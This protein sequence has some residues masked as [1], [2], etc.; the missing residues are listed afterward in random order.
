MLDALALEV[1]EHAVADRP[2]LTLA[3]RPNAMSSR[4]VA[5]NSRKRRGSSR[6]S[7]SRAPSW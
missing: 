6:V 4:F 2:E 1:R 3:E 5:T 7:A